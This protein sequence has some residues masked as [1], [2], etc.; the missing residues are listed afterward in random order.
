MRFFDFEKLAL[1]DIV[2]IDLTYPE[3]I[4]IT[5]D[6]LLRDLCAR[7]V[8]ECLSVT[9]AEAGRLSSLA[10]FELFVEEH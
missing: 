6:S 10:L 7:E 1:I 5:L 3:D 4:R 2:A 8:Y 9:F